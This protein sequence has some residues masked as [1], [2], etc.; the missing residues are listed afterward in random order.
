MGNGAWLRVSLLVYWSLNILVLRS[1]N[2]SIL[3]VILQVNE[4]LPLNLI[5][6]RKPRLPAERLVKPLHGTKQC[7]HRL[8]YHPAHLARRSTPSYRNRCGPVLTFQP[9]FALIPA[10]N[11]IRLCF[12]F[13]YVLSVTISSS[14][15][16]FD[17]WDIHLYANGKLHY[18]FERCQIP[19]RTDRTCRSAT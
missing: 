15:L 16:A 11:L 7:I 8:A 17:A 2:V 18:G 6:K 13:S 4:H 14:P 1:G 9:P 5:D 10:Q 3:K 19:S 12:Q